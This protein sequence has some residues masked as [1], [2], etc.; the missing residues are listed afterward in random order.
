MLEL[1][2]TRSRKHLGIVNKCKNKQKKCVVKR[3]LTKP[4]N[5]MCANLRANMHIIMLFIDTE[6]LIYRESRC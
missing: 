3:R 6:D 2:S 4:K 1:I 5:V